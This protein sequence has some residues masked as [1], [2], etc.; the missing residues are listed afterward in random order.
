[1]QTFDLHDPATDAEFERQL[2]EHFRPKYREYG[3]QL[4][5]PQS[6]IALWQEAKAWL[7][8]RSPGFTVTEAMSGDERFLRCTVMWDVPAEAR[9][10]IQAALTEM[11]ERFDWLSAGV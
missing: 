6:A 11:T 7:S 4:I 1:M 10:D 3:V 8:E 2:R 5:F 9:A